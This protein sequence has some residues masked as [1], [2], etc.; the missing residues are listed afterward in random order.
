MTISWSYQGITCLT[1]FVDNTPKYQ[2][3]AFCH[4]WTAYDAFALSRLTS[5]MSLIA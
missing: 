2:Y 3:L 5:R 4:I 1:L